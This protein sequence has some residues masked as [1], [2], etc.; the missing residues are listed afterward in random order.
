MDK[1][2]PFAAGDGAKVSHVRGSFNASSGSKKKKK[3]KKRNIGAL[4]KHELKSHTPQSRS[5]KKKQQRKT[6]SG[7]MTSLFSSPGS[8]N[9][10][11]G[12]LSASDKLLPLL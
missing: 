2:I 12:R 5:G 7:P 11:G 8:G 6:N 10:E 1:V 4:S 9:S 3:K